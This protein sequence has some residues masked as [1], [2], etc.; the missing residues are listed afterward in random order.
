MAGALRL[1]AL[2]LGQ[3]LV[4]KTAGALR[5]PALHSGQPLVKKT[6]GALRLPA[7]HSGQPLV[8]K[9]AGALR[10]PALPRC[11]FCRPGKRSAPGNI[12]NAAR[13]APRYPQA[14]CDNTRR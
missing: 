1:P 12:L 9:T 11:I 13:S 7:L 10:L 5:L 4:K 8:K 2:H 6:A 14:W 3:P